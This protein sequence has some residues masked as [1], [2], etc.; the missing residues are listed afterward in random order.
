MEAASRA[1]VDI[2]VP[3]RPEAFLF[4][5]LAAVLFLSG[6]ASLVYEVLWFRMLGLVFGSTTHALSVLL[7]SF[8]AGLA[9]GSALFGRLGAGLRN[10]LRVY[11]WIELGVASYCALSPWLFGQIESVYVHVAGASL[12]VFASVSRVAL[13]AAALLVPT[14][15]MGA[16]LPLAVEVA[17]RHELR[18]TSRAVGSLY[19]ANTWGG[20]AGTLAA[21]FVLIMALGVR[22]S[23]WTTAGLQALL[24]AGVWLW[25]LK[26]MFDA[27]PDAGERRPAPVVAAG[28]GGGLEA[29]QAPGNW[30]MVLIVALSGFAAMVYEVCWTRLLALTI[31]SSVYAFALVLA[32]F[33][34]AISAGSLTYGWARRFEARP[35]RVLGFGELAIGLASL[36][37]MA[38][39]ELLPELLIRGFAVLQLNF[40]SVTIVS[41]LLAFGAVFLP[42]FFFGLIF[43][44][45]AEILAGPEH[46]QALPGRG[47]SSHGAGRAYAWNTAGA[48]L[49]AAS[50][51][52]ILIAQMGTQATLTAA[53]WLNLLCCAGALALAR[54]GANAW[55]IAGAGF[56]AALLLSAFLPRWDVQALSTGAHHDL[57]R[58]VRS[59][60][61]LEEMLALYRAKMKRYRPV[62]SR[63][64]KESWV[65]V[66]DS[67]EGVRY[68]KNNGRVDASAGPGSTDVSTQL[69]LGHLPLVVK[70][71]APEEVLVI[72]LGTGMTL[73]AVLAHPVKSVDLV[74]IE[75]AVI[76]ASRHFRKWNR[77]ATLDPRVSLIVDDGRHHLLTTGKR[78]GVVV[79]D[80]PNPW[81]AGAANLFTA[82]FYRLVARRLEP[83]GVFCQ[84]L[85]PSEMSALD[86]EA[87]LAAIRA[88]FPYV[89]LWS[90]VKARRADLEWDMF[91]DAIAIASSEPLRMD[92]KAMQQAMSRPLAAH[93]LEGLGIASADKLLEYF[94]FGHETTTRL[95]SGIAANTDDKPIL[96]F[97][98]PRRLYGFAPRLEAAAFHPVREPVWRYL[99]NAGQGHAT[100]KRLD[101]VSYYLRQGLESQA[102]ALLAE[103]E[104]EG[105]PGHKVRR[106]AHRLAQRVESRAAR[107]ELLVRLGRIYDGCK[108]GHEAASLYTEAVN[109]DP[110]ALRH[111]VED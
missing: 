46:S 99:S 3:G 54:A 83:G 21:A 55:R 91:L 64:G 37:I 45:S 14:A 48:V 81:V 95:C 100:R 92:F 15:L 8:M 43:P 59:D 72:G 87:A 56:A 16:T 61:P 58:L 34:A 33:L 79:S 49:G 109:L 85:P 104:R 90:S 51:G 93:D 28:A 76:E 5:L 98:G 62:F 66:Q 107:P 18:T 105:A 71:A 41:G 102:L 60:R 96:E 97:L 22:A 13:S 57:N 42:A 68:L 47:H 108:M 35:A 10:P 23:V 32:A 82:G 11:A 12:P 110:G 70:G 63:E 94:V 20:V 101:L 50:A 25:S 74:E 40:W 89:S 88:E 86:Y 39:A 75:P 44:A 103:I 53:A 4:G 6:A 29:S 69:L 38:V 84:W 1:R 77:G 9:L 31:G 2:S 106:L 65:L 19:A 36:A 52:V 17:A 73:A 30:P 111:L 80:P 7:A 27:L 78:Y 24:G 26:P 67:P